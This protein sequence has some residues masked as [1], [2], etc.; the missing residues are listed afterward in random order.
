MTLPRTVTVP[1]STGSKPNDFAIRNLGACT[2][3]SVIAD[4]SKDHGQTPR[5]VDDQARI[6]FDDRIASVSAVDDPTRLPALELAGP[7]HKLFFDPSETR[8][9]IVTCGGLCPGLNDVIRGLVMQAYYRYGVRRIYGFRYGYRGFIGEYGDDPLILEPEMVSEI[10]ETGG[11][12]LASSRGKQDTVRIVDCL[13]RYAI[14]MLFTIG[15]DG[16]LRGALDIGREVDKRGLRIAIIGIPKTIDNDIQYIDQSFG[17]ETAYGQ[18]VEA[19]VGAHNEARG[20]LNGIGLVKVMGRHSGFL[21]CHA[22]LATS[23]VNF[24]IIP[25]M[26]IGATFVSNFMQA[27][28]DRLTRRH[29]AVILVAEGAGQ[30]YLQS[31]DSETDASG[32]IKLE[33]IGRFLADHIHA[34]L[35]DT[36]ME[37]S[38]K[39]IDPSYI[40]RSVPASPADSVY[41]WQLAQNAVHA[42]MAGKTELV[43]GKWHGRL[44]HVPIRQAIAGRKQVDPQ[45][46]LWLS[47]LETTGQPAVFE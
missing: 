14:G 29:H 41:C 9:G 21:A 38:L 23:H 36:D 18:A 4:V 25:E 20:T 19:I 44:V 33:D 6:L 7:R 3:E 12:I 43:V 24:V 8:I 40:L 31:E 42:A 46:D 45:S 34:Y 35:D 27:L 28:R 1:R 26:P 11:S 47:V 10:H 2:H 32:N 16:T 15:G 37:Y 5:F 22:A 17:Y 30:A 13:E 39:Y